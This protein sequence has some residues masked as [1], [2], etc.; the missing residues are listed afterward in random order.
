[1]KIRTKLIISTSVLLAG[2]AA[3]AAASLL[4]VKGIETHVH[5]LTDETVPLYTDV[6]RLRY[7]V[8]DLASDFFELGKAEDLAQLE[9]VSNKIV[10]NIR[11]AESISQQLRRH[12][13]SQA[14]RY[15]T[16]FEQEFQRMR[17]AV[18]KRLE[19]E[20]YYKAQATE[21]RQVLAQIKAAA[22][23]ARG[24]I[25]L[26]DSQAQ[27]TAAEVQLQSQR[28]NENARYLT[29]VRKSILDMQ[30]SLAETEAVK[31]RFRIAPLRERLTAAVAHL[32][33]SGE[34]GISPAQQALRENVLATARRLLDPASGLMTLRAGLLA[35]GGASAAQQAQY[36]ALKEQIAATLASAHLRLAEE[37]DPIEL[38][39]AIGRD[40]LAEAGRYMRTSARIE[41]ASGEIN[42][43][44]D[45]ISIDVGEV[46]LATAAA[47]VTRLGD[48]IALRIGA[49]HGDMATMQTL[50]QSIGQLGLLAET[51][52]VNTY[53]DAVERS[54]QRLVQAKGSVLDSQTALGEVIDH[55]RAF[56]R[57]QAAYSAQQVARITGQQQDAVVKVRDGV[58]HAFVLILGIALVLLLA[59]VAI[60]GLISASIAGPLARLSHAIAHIRGGKALSVRVAQH[61]SDELGQLITGFNGMLEHVE[62]RDLALK[63]AKAEAD[64]ANRAKSEFLAKMSHE[65]RTPMNGVLGMTELLQRTELSPKQQRFVHTVHRS[66]E[67]LL[68]I[69]DD[70]LD[71]SKIEAGKLVLEDIPFD[72]RQ[73]IDDVVA[74]FANGIQRKA[75]EFTCRIASDVPQHVRGDPVRLRQIL[76][77]LLNNAT[78]FTERGEISVDVSCPA[79]GQ[80]RLEV[81]DTGIGMAPEAAAAVFQ[82]FRQAD[83]TTSRKY[84]G[85]GLGLAIIKQLAEMMGG[86]IVLHSVAGQ[87]SSFAVTVV[88]GEVA[89]ED[90]PAAP[91]PRVPLNA[92]NVLIVDDNATNRS[93]LLQHAIEWQMAAA[94]AADGAEAL[95]LLQGALR[96]GR[97]FDLA[98]IDMRM[99]VMDG[100]ELV[101][102]IKGD[103]RMAALKIIMLSSLDA[104][105]DLRQVTALGVEYCLTKPVRALELRHCVEAVGGFGTLAPATAAI[106][107]TSALPAAPDA[108]GAAPGQAPLR[109]LLV[110][111]NAINQEIALAMLE[112]TVYEATPAD[113]GRRALALWERYPFDVILMDCQMP[114]MDGFEA[115]RRL[116]RMEAQ[117]GRPRTPIIALTANAILGD[118]E[119]CLE[120]GMDDY[121][122][123]PYTRAALLAVLARWRPSAAVETAE[124]TVEATEAVPAAARGANPVLDAAALQN[125]R[126]MRRPGRPD[127]LG[128]IIDLFHS[129]APRLLGQLEVAAE[130]SDAAALQLAAHT[131]KSS[132]AN[133]GALGLSA[134]C[135]EIEQ[136]ARGN[137]VGSALQHIRG[138]QQE[139]DRVLA[140]LAIE[141]ET[142]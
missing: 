42:L 137:D 107:A 60:T 58:R 5:G 38:Q 112:D 2:V 81:R 59:C 90:A 34:R 131:L 21:M 44:V 12:G 57:E 45:A 24:R 36:A 3:M 41:D 29:D 37:L 126:A 124:A 1:M 132:C 14:P 4:L 129:D 92:L 50:L 39:L 27:A 113:N 78:K 73:M 98:I 51:R 52:S 65:I 18:R 100:A 43:A 7:T 120:A 70:I 83:S 28:L 84:G 56:E 133:V 79:A 75:I 87:G 96:S 69:I 30:I 31:S 109:M 66:G 54:G 106:P 108:A 99:P 22:K 130:A 117:Q 19:N 110:E 103:A 25:R 118:R 77:N 33:G 88:V 76:T 74:L 64:A 95:N 135:R 49:L 63:Q 6:L 140:A 46:M 48:D 55:V 15:H 138:I 114:E 62:Q 13:E 80:V 128:R 123:K 40:R 47:D 116:R 115:T 102:A 11:T 104:S 32:A 91:P 10:A 125:L 119:L 35:E 121:L 86:N 134:T 141:K 85:T 17:V 53:L 71:F 67:S 93:I 127:V 8:Q 82:P 101:R 136:Y 23:G 105:A 72:L 97:P 111:D 20:A 68:S 61:G 89:P 94:S 142:L 139:L 16:A 122:A 9:Q 26:V